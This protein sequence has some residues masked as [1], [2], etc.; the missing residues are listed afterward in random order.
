M[1]AKQSAAE[2]KALVQERRLAL[3]QYRQQ[4]LAQFLNI[5]ADA[6]E[7]TLTETGKPVLAQPETLSFNHSH[8]QKHYALA[9]S[10][11]YQHIGVDIEDLD[12]QVRF[13]SLAQHAFHAEELA[14]WEAIDFDP[15]YWF[16]VWTTKEAVLKASGLGI[17]INLNELNTHVHPLGNGGMCQHEKIGS[18]AYQNIQ[19]PSAM[20][21]VAWA[22]DASCRGFNF[23]KIELYSSLTNEHIA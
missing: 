21:T 9:Y 20:L 11:R 2:R 12:R 13:Q 10:D 17:R 19:L 8:S 15:A 6:L 1:F 23:P 16:K 22:A 5:D 7:I 3:R 4:H 14:H 18:Y